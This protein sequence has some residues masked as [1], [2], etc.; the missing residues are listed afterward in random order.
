MKKP[1]FISSGNKGG[2]GKSLKASTAVDYLLSLNLRVAVV[3]TDL[4]QPDVRNRYQGAPG[5]VMGELN[6]G[7][8]A[9]G[10]I[11]R[12]GTWVESKAEIIDAVV[13]NSP[14]GGG[15]I[16]DPFASILD[17]VCSALNFRLTVSW[18]IGAT[19]ED[20]GSVRRSLEGGLLGL[21]S[22]RRS[23]C[24][25]GWMGDPATWPWARSP[26][27]RAAA[28]AGVGEIVVPRLTQQVMSQ[29][30][31]RN[32]I[33]LATLCEPAGGLSIASRSS[34]VRWRAAM[35]STIAA[36]TGQ[37]RAEDAVDE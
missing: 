28:A 12:L 25:A 16:F 31:E 4:T 7:G 17:D 2:L 30:V 6:L 10:A 23:V 29:L 33:P 24:L 8:D 20:T 5:V 34:L 13:V 32:T 36:L 21:Q 18:M 14:S 11:V 19:I 27:R 35:H 1:A 22:A 15:D 3:E 26:V 9:E 37:T